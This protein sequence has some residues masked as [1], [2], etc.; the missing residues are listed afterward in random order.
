MSVPGREDGPWLSLEYIHIF[1]GLQCF[2]PLINWCCSVELTSYPQ[3][4]INDAKHKKP[5]VCRNYAHNISFQSVFC[6]MS[7]V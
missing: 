1:N 7:D 6:V 3:I 4:I 5:N 2:K